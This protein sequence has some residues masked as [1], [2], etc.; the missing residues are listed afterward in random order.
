MKKIRCNKNTMMG[1]LVVVL[2][3]CIVYLVYTHKTSIIEGVDPDQPN[4]AEMARVCNACQRNMAGPS[5]APGDACVGV[6]DPWGKLLDSKQC[7]CPAENA[8]VT[9]RG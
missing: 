9:M 1:A 8:C 7:P 3:L 4:C 2:G 5:G 6:C